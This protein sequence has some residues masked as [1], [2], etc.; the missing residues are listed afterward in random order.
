MKEFKF[1]QTTKKERYFSE[2]LDRMDDYFLGGIHARPEEIP[3][4]YWN[5]FPQAVREGSIGNMQLFIQGWEAAVAGN[6]VNP[7]DDIEC[8]EAW[9]RGYMGAVNRINRGFDQTDVEY[10]H[11]VEYEFIDVTPLLYEPTSFQPRRHMLFRHRLTGAIVKGQR[12][13]EN[14]PMWNFPDVL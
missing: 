14:H 1:L 13:D 3:N 8:R 4:R 9:N 12:I 6:G 11:T 7:F 2:Y 5:L 10:Y